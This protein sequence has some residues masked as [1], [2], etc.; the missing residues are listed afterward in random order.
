MNEISNINNLEWLCFDLDGTLIDSVPDITF[1][2]NEMLEALGLM[3][4]E[5]SLARSWV[6]NGADI[7]IQRA[8]KYATKNKPE[9][10]LFSEAKQLFIKAYDKNLA[11]K[12]TIYPDCIEVLKYFFE[13]DI[14]IGC[15][16]NKPRQFTSPLLEK[17]DLSQYFSALVC[18]DD[19]EKKKPE[20]EPVLEAIRQLNGEPSKGYMVGDSETDILAA[21]RAGAG[22]IYVS[23]GYN[24]GVPVEK[25]GPICINR[26][27]ELQLLFK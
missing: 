5:E 15:V 20:P 10:N 27:C 2:I 7:L 13:R 26:L 4:V 11:V 21:K 17:L 8:L 22:A 3:A 12:T 18:G 16:T 9:E 23:Y 24:R 6:G 25:H 1:S 19:L 14:P